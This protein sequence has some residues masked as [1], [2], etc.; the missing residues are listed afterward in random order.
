MNRN[1]GPCYYKN[2]LSLEKGI[3][4]QWSLN[5]GFTVVL[6]FDLKQTYEI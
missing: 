3:S 2:G 1:V 4:S 5:T 6:I